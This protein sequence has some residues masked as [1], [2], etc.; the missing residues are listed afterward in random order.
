[1][2]LAALPYLGSGLAA[3]GGNAAR[4][5]E[6]RPASH[7]GVARWAVSVSLSR[8]RIGPLRLRTSR[9]QRA[10]H[11]SSQPWVEHDLRIANMGDRKVRLGDTRTSAYLRGPVDRAL[12]GADEGCGY[13]FASGSDEI[14]VG[15]CASYLDV[16]TLRPGERIKRT[17]TLFKGLKGMSSLRR[18]TYVFRKRIRYKV[19]GRSTRSHRIR[20]IYRIEPR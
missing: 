16:P 12:L 14:D 5:D 3:G 15:V 18:G 2:G 10:P 20:L 11:T 13:G 7:A 9:M 4:A 17:V 19:R 1:M 8:R 6:V